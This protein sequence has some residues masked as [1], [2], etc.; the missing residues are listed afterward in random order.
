MVFAGPG[1]RAWLRWFLRLELGKSLE[2]G[3]RLEERTSLGWFTLLNTVEARD[4]SVGLLSI[5][6]KY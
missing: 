5:L 4:R 1:G 3:Q 2:G 6:E